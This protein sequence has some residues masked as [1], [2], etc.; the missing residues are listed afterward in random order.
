MMPLLGCNDDDNNDPGTDKLPVAAQEFI[1]TYFN[2]Y[3]VSE[4]KVNK[5]ENERGAIYESK[6]YKSGTKSG[7]VT[8]SVEIEF[9]KNGDWRDIESLVDGTPFPADVLELLP[10]AIVQYVN[11]NYA[12]I[13]IEE[14]E[15][16]AYGYK[17]EL[18]NDKELLFDKNGDILSDTQS[19]QGSETG[20]GSV[21][22]SIEEFINTHFPDYTIAYIKNE[23][24]QEYKKVYLK[25]G[26]TKSYKIV[27]DHEENW[28]EVEGDDDFNLPVPESVMQLLPG[29][30]S[31]YI[32]S[33]YPSTYVVEVKKKISGYK[34]ELAN[35][36]DLLFNTNGEFLGSDDNDQNVDIN[37]LPASIKDF[38]ATYYP[39]I[40]IREIEKKARHDSNGKMYEVELVNGVEIDFNQDGAWLSIDGNDRELPESFIQTL[41]AGISLYI[42]TNYPNA[43]ISE[44]EKE[45]NSYKVEIIRDRNDFELYFDMNG[46]FLRL[47]D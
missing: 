22:K 25:N 31:G 46:N 39:N 42:D 9:D 17:V 33:N 6:L 47:D 4:V 29:N 40:L 34:I 43:Y 2:Q 28:I 7:S 8:S 3:V 14:I 32:K 16:K 26:Y 5:T 13:G 15:K 38:L 21:S 30:I 18:I 12:G 36:V 45:N 10:I 44:I 11:T 20:N 19:G 35:D 24:G 1:S 41:P 23:N 27:F 37:S